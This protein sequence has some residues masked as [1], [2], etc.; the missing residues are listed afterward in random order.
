MFTT[1][2]TARFVTTPSHRKG[3]AHWIHAMIA[4]QRSRVTLAN[5]DAAG[6]LDVSLSRTDVAA[7]LTRP[8]WSVP[9]QR[10][11]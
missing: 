5:H 11:R 2:T 6:L 9:N 1:A 7:E 8:L 3:F 4:A 10:R